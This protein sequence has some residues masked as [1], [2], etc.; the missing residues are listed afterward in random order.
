MN[1]IVEFSDQIA[2][3]F[4]P[5][6]II[7]FGSYAYGTP[8]EESDVDLLI[9]MPFEGRSRSKSLEIWKA[10]RPSFSVDLILRTPEDATRRYREWDP[11]VREALDKGKVLC[12]RN[13]QGV[14]R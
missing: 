9:V 10:L 2:R 3:Q 6:K 8:N 1:E 11:L 4:H 14:D 5:E 12:E 13:D 7:L